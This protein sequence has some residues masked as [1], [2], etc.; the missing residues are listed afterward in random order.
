MNQGLAHGEDEGGLRWMTVTTL[1][2]A[3]GV[4]LRMVSP[5][6]GGV[7]LNWNIVMYALAIL[8]CRPTPKQGMGIG[9][10]SGMVAMLTSKAALPYANLVSDPL[11]GFVCAWLAGN[12]ILDRRLGT[13]SI[14]PA[15]V[16][17]V[18]TLISGGAF[19]TVTK[20]IL[21]LPM[22]IYL[23]AML[24][25]VLVVA[26]LGMAVGQMLYVP[27]NRM[28]NAG[29]SF[30]EKQGFQLKNIELQIPKG[31][32]CVVTGV[33]GAGKT[34]LLLTIAGARVKYLRE[35]ADSALIVHG[36]DILRTERS[37]RNQTVGMV[38]ADYEGQLVT[39]TV[40]DEIAFSLE[41][42]GLPREAI[43]RKRA[44][45]LDLVG[46]AG[47]E[48]R[49][50]ASLSGGQK[51][52]LA[53]AVM[54]AVDPPVLVLDEPV[55]AIDPEGAIDIYRLLKE[56]NTKYQKTIV[57]A[58]HDLKYV[59]DCATQLVVLADGT[60]KFS[61]TLEDTLRYMHARKVYP[62]AVPLKWKI[63]FEL[64]DTTCSY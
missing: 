26:L 41:N 40:G 45:V 12:R 32:F 31:A 10:V 21:D 5:S 37:V 51:Q 11:A 54:L 7:S 55:A 36:M 19:V 16:V 15:G 63:Y 38:M 22:H 44:E 57:V 25:T 42:L 59:S 62:E 17:L 1:L 8:L 53:I 24:P 6:I 49:N 14:E 3:V 30:G 50:V 33:N 4:I 58:E 13:V 64:G 20:V 34:S 61:G 23:Y 28:F 43:A 2:L 29:K 9:V 39:E 18:T 27:A 47:L 46:L 48:E 56:L 52:R 35:I 60:L